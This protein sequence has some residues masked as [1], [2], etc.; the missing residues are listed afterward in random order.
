MTAGSLHP[1]LANNRCSKPE[2][3][4]SQDYAAGLLQL[5]IP[6]LMIGDFNVMPT[7]PDVHKPERWR[8]DA[9]VRPEVRR[10]YAD[11]VTKGWAD[12]IRHLHPYERIY[13]FWKY[14]RNSFERD[15]GLGIDH[16]LLSPVAAPWLK[17]ASV[18]REPRSWAHASDHAP[19]MIEVDVPEDR[20]GA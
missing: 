9:L 12:A 11:L 19:V 10:A 18:R 4:P 8:K 1:L 15:A 6:V 17:S 20:S 2:G 7:D 5:E 16:I 13:T 3:D 14:W